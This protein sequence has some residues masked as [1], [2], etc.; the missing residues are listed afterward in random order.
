MEARVGLEPTATR[1]TVWRSNQLSYRAKMDAGAGFEPA[2]SSLW[3]GE[4]DHLLYPA[5]VSP[6][7][8]AVQDSH[9]DDFDK[10]FLRFA[11]ICR[12]RLLINFR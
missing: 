4:I 12:F 8:G 11:L 2:L 7:G 9:D 3:A 1:L 6:S 10:L 5:L